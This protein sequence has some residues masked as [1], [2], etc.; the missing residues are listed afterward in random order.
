VTFRVKEGYVTN[1]TP[2]EMLAR[3]SAQS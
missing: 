3:L 1:L 2:E